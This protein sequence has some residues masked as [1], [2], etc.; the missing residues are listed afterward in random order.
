LYGFYPLSYF[1]G[2]DGRLIAVNDLGSTG[3]AIDTA[4]SYKNNYNVVSYS[5]IED[6]VGDVY[7]H[8]KSASSPEAEITII[9]SKGRIIVDYDPSSHGG[10]AAANSVPNIVLKLNLAKKGVEGAKV[11]AAGKSGYGPMFI[12]A[13]GSVK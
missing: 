3:K 5:P 10:K 1:V 13:R 6:L 2:L 11:A 9:D 12:P 8:F 7:G 4:F